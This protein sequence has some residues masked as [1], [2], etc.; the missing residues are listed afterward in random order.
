VT[1]ALHEA[2]GHDTVPVAS[3]PLERDEAAYQLGK[4]LKR[5]EAHFLKA[6]GMRDLGYC[7]S[8]WPQR[9]SDSKPQ[10]RVRRYNLHKCSLMRT[11]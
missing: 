2:V 9:A 11:F 8:L 1:L 4:C 3:T 5:S 7:C 6:R 10:V